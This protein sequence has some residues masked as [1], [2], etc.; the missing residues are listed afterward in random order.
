M[1]VKKV[2]N[3]VKRACYLTL[4]TLLVC[5]CAEVI[6]LDGDPTSQFVLVYGRVTDGK[7]GNEISLALTSERSDGAQEP[8]SGA[9]IALMK[10]EELLGRY[11]EKSESP[12]D[13]RLNYADSAREGEAYHIEIELPN[14]ERILSQP[15]VMPSLA[16]KDSLSIQVDLIEFVVDERGFRRDIRAAQLY[17]DT[18][19]TNLEN[20]FFLKWNILESY[21]AVETPRCCGTPP[22]P[23]YIGNDI[24]GQEIRIYDGAS[25]KADV[26]PDRLFR[27]TEVDGRF[28]FLYYYQVIQSTIDQQA[29][30]YWSKI[31]EISNLSGFVFDKTVANIQGNLYY[32]DDPKSQVFGYFEVARVDTTRISTDSDEF[33]FFLREPC[34]ASPEN[35]APECG[36]CL[37][38]ENSTHDRPYFY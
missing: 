6:D 28:A 12:G 7:A 33:N 18:K 31:E 29:Y 21:I 38:I 17:V 1:K 34:P 19:V 5:T 20:D 27:T 25:L 10:G 8:I 26:I 4:V 11:I 30:E 22:P 13:Y 24:T 23:C 37:I 36:S 2:L 35:F 32:P 9:T 16:A 14:G 3:G 15:S